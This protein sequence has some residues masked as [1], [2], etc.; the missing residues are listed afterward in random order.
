MRDYSITVQQLINILD[1][2]Q[3]PVVD[4][5]AGVPTVVRVKR[6]QQNAVRIELVETEGESLERQP[7]P[8]LVD[9]PIV[10]AVDTVNIFGPGSHESSRKIDYVTRDIVSTHGRVMCVAEQT[11]DDH[12]RVVIN[13]GCVKYKKMSQSSETLAWHVAECIIRTLVLH[14][15]DPADHKRID[16][17][18]DLFYDRLDGVIDNK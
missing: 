7:L 8:E 1:R 13:S 9:Q 16:E 3:L 2:V 15:G 12:F 18:I 11:T 4:E 14:T 10:Q 5:P 17:L 6:A